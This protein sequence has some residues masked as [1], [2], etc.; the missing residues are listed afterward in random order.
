VSTGTVELQHCEQGPV[1]APAVLLAP[2]LG[3]TLAM[4]DHV[5]DRLAGRYRVVRF[6]TRGHGGSPA[7]A[8]PCSVSALAGD[9]VGLADKLGIDRFAFVG[10]SLGGAVGQVLAIEHPDRLTALVLCCTGPSFGDPQTWRDRAAQVRAEG[11]G[12]LA[13]PTRGRWFTA[14]FRETHPREVDRLID[15]LTSTSPEGYAACCDAL[16]SYDV[17]ERLAEIQ[18]PTRVIAGAEDEVSPPSVGRLMAERIPDADLVVID[19]ASHIASAAQPEAFDT[20]VLEH[21]DRHL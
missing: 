10:L 4:W 12:F 5:A 20:A 13:E 15:M 9:V 17:T 3:T 6:D 14:S 11:M 19:D 2:S 1:D 8:G 16:A 21:L 18:V 7:A